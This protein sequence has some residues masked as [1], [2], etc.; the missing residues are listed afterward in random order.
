MAITSH[1]LHELLDE[2]HDSDAVVLQQAQQAAQ[3]VRNSRHLLVLTGAGIS[4]SAGVSCYRGPEGVWTCQAQGR[5]VPR[6]TP[7]P[8]AAPTPTHMGLLALQEAGLLGHIGSQNVDGLHV[9]SGIPLKQITE[10]HGNMFKE[11]CPACSNEYTREA[12]MYG[13]SLV[14][15]DNSHMCAGC[16]AGTSGKCHCTGGTCVECGATLTDTII[17]FEELPRAEHLDM[18]F[19]QAAAADVCLVLGTS[20]A[21]RPFNELPRDVKGHGGHVIIVNAQKTPLDNLCDVGGVR[22]FAETDRFFLSLL[23]ALGLHAPVWKPGC[24]IPEVRRQHEV[25]SELAELIA[26]QQ[27]RFGE[28]TGG[29]FC[30]V[31]STSCPH[32]ASRCGSVLGEVD[33]AGPCVECGRVGENWVCGQCQTLHCGR[34]LCGHMLRHEKDTGHC[35]GFSLRDSSVWCFACDCYVDEGS[36]QAVQPLYQQLYYKKHGEWD[37]RPLIRA[38]PGS[39]GAGGA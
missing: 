18:L 13:G 22:I 7:I 33:V 6:G 38:A 26:S 15:P 21:V 11:R 35:I 3:L 30:I 31:P 36:V 12:L 20:L 2:I 27:S 19:A 4:T 23:E 28:G 37:P 39:L 10:I 1:H 34:Y 24:V 25:E 29:G 17:N 14:D 32:A 5:P 9:R 8:D 16:Q